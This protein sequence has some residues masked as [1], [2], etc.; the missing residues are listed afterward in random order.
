AIAGVFL[1]RSDNTVNANNIRIYPGAM[2]PVRTTGGSNGASVEPLQVGGD[3]ALANFVLDDLKSSVDRIMLNTGL[4]EVGDGV[5]SAT[6]F[7]ERLKDMQQSIGAPFSRILREGIVP[8]LESHLQVL[9]EIGILAAPEDGIFRLNAGEIELRFTSPLVQGQ[10]AREVERFVQGVQIVQQVG[11]PQ[12][13]E[14]LGLSM[15]IEEATDWVFK[16]L[17]VDPKLLRTP[18]EKEALQQMAG[19]AAAAQQ[20]APVDP[21]MEDPTAMEGVAA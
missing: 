12:A 5:R 21:G 7:I 1:V 4:P 3:H 14:L 9:A 19:Q 2:I 18:D 16:K 17:N 6:E 8:M 20:G 13:T 10:A 11:G 15:K